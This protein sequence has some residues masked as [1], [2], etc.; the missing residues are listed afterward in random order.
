MIK[1][2]EH[3]KKEYTTK[4]KN[5]KYCSRSCSATH[6]QQGKPSKNPL[7]NL[8][9]RV[10][11]ICGGVKNRKSKM[12]LSCKRETYDESFDNTTL[13]Q[14]R[15]K[16]KISSSRFQWIRK[17]ARNIIET[18][19]QEKVCAYCKNHEWDDIL[20]VH[21]IKDIAEFQMIL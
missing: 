2:C 4:D 21:H 10:C 20:E 5:R 14:F 12:C 17:K 6:T 8:N 18:S 7:T 9:N 19:N 3:C 1:I 15:D 16:S 11:P 13:K